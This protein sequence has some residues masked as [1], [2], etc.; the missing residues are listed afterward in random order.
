MGL[1]LVASSGVAQTRV[2][3]MGW[4]V[5]SGDNDDMV[6]AEQL[7]EFE[8]YDLFGLC[9]V[10]QENATL[11][12]E[13]VGYGEG[14]YGRE[15]DYDFRLGTTGR[16]DRLLAIW[17]E[18][19]FEYLDHQELLRVEKNGV[20]YRLNDGN[21]R[22]PLAVKLKLK[23][24]NVDFWFMV[25][26]LARGNENLR[27]EQAEGLRIWA[28]DQTLPVI[29][30]GGY[31]FDYN[32]DEGKGNQGLTNLLEG[33]T[34]EWVKPETLYKTSLHP[35]YNGILDFIFVAHVP[36]NWYFE[37][38]ILRDGFTGPDDERVSDHR[39]VE[40]VLFIR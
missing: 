13:S 23:S 10:M 18:D 14:A 39:P 34:V 9:E 1:M 24:L 2:L 12:A 26:H 7:K 33:S 4:N 31:N 21:H 38:K 30:V 35:R 6:I 28:E 19:R 32:I 29:A 20:I 37:S 25:N 16:S 11:Y 22:S 40:G 15:T 5:E 3:F 17:D 27:Q 36:D 8:G